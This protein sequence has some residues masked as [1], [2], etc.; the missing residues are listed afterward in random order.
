MK[1]NVSRQIHSFSLSAITTAGS[2]RQEQGNDCQGLH[3]NVS[4]KW[5][6]C[7]AKNW[8]W[9]LLRWQTNKLSYMSRSDNGQ[10]FFLFMF[11]TYIYLSKRLCARIL[12]LWL[13]LYH[14]KGDLQ[15]SLRANGGLDEGVFQKCALNSKQEP[16]VSHQVKNR[17]FLFIVAKEKA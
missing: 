1:S 7:V 14:M 5:D 4:Y 15:A 11:S 2:G 10:L 16:Q 6:I 17:K 12:K 9:Q 8:F 3:H 13:Q